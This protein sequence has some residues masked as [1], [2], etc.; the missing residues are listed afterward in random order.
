MP[1]AIRKKIA[2]LSLFIAFSLLIE[3]VSFVLLDFGLVPK[4]LVFNLGFVLF[5]ATIL[6]LIPHP[7]VQFALTFGL[8]LLQMMITFVNINL[9]TITGEIF[10]W[11]M[12][13]LAMDATEAVQ[14]TSMLDYSSLLIFM[15]IAILILVLHRLIRRKINKMLFIGKS[16]RQSRLYL[17]ISTFIVAA[18]LFLTGFIMTESS[19]GQLTN[20]IQGETEA[21]IL[22]SDAYLYE[23]LYLPEATL[24]TFGSF[25]YY[26]KGLAF[27]LGLDINASAS[28]EILDDYFRE[29]TSETNAYTG[30]SEGNNVIMILLESFEYFAIDAEL[31]PTLYDLF[32]VDGILLDNFHGKIKTDVA[33]GGSLFGSYPSTGSLFRNYQNNDYPFSLPNRLK[34][35]SAIE[36]AHSFHNNTGSF[37][38]RNHAH[39]HFGFDEH[40]DSGD[41]ALS[42]SDFWINSDEEMMRDQ[43][44]KMIPDDGIRFLTY[45]TTF[46]MH[47]GYEYREAFEAD[48][49]Y[50]DTIG[51]YPGDDPFDQYMRTYMAAAINLDKAMAILL[52]RLESTHLHDSTT[53]ILFGDHTAYYYG[54][55]GRAK[56]A[57]N[58]DP[59]YIDQYRLPA[60]IYDSK[61]KNALLADEIGNIG[62]FTSVMDFVPT[63]LNLLGIAFNPLQYLGADLFSAEQTVILSKQGGIFNDIYYTM[64]GATVLY[65]TTEA[66]PSAWLE[67]QAS[68][69]SILKKN[70]HLN[71]MYKVNYFGIEDSL[72]DPVI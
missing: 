3:T 22:R 72:D 7:E 53:L 27:Y 29:G 5:V 71:L 35:E 42:E 68:V 39:E 32:Y 51:Y 57:E 55:S 10:F 25:T 28:V 17:V 69:A 61:L 44:E 6:M 41:M 54:F 49:A 30:I 2:Y 46:T 26:V 64:D 9:Q 1:S 67:F 20:A 45:I 59:L 48:Y 8:L 52:D 12:L 40:F 66:S 50:F 14:G 37:Y 24:R 18:F 36:I 4:L 62:K 65:Q 70:Q 34:A 21:V 58:E 13:S 19:Y 15:A 47:G 16:K 11:D 31:T 38:N 33:E 60:V 56:N 23:T 43:V 63:L